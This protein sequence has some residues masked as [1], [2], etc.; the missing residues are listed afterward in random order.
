M[1]S[2]QKDDKWKKAKQLLAQGYTWIEV[3]SYY[4][5][6]GGDKVKVYSILDREKF[7]ILDMTKA[8]RVILEDAEGEKVFADYL[9]VKN[10]R[11]VFEY[12]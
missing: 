7:L 3:I 11:K 5:L 1:T 9:D 6:L 4:K 10:S 8:K 2:Y 12:R